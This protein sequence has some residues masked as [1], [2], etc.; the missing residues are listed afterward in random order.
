MCMVIKK[1]TKKQDGFALLISLIVVGVVI[2]V[3]LTILDLSITQVRLSD[4][5]KQSE[6]AFHA[7]NA[8]VEC[9]LYWRRTSSEDMLGGNAISPECFGSTDS[10]VTPIN[11]PSGDDPGEI[12]DGEVNLYQYEFSWGT[13]PRCTKITTAVI[14]AN[15]SAGGATL[16]N[17]NQV[18]GDGGVNAIPGFPAGDSECEVG[19]QCTI[20]AVRGYNQNCNNITN[21]GTTEREVLLQF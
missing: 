21:F 5:A 4:N 12:E 9:G 16:H 8:G 2:S 13:E 15:L 20:M 14:T 1:I 19:A 6:L 10:S 18:V 3:G 7:A 17:V 11:V